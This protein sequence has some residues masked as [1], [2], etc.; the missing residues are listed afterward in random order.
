MP[1]LASLRRETRAALCLE[2]GKCATLCPLAGRGDFSARR[3]ASLHGDDP[4]GVPEAADQRC[5]TCAACE[6]RCPQQVHFS[7]WVRGLRERSDPAERW[8]CPHGS[9]LEASARL[10]ADAALR[11]DL[12]WI[13]DDLRVAEQGEIALFVGCLP[14]F[15]A[16]FGES[17]GVRTLDSARAAIRLLNQLGIEPVIAEEERCCGHDLLWTG[18]RQSFQKLAHG[19]VAA[20][21][22]RGV[23][24]VL[25][26]CAECCRTWRLDYA[27]AVPGTL[28]RVEHLSEFL[29]DRLGEGALEP[30]GDEA[31]VR[32]TYQD[33]CR[34][35]RHLDVV[36]APRRLLAASGEAELVEMERSGRDATCCG[37]PGFTHCDSTSLALQRQR[38]EAALL[39]GATRLLTACPK[40]LIHFRC[41]QQLQPRACGGVGAIEIQ[42]LTV[43]AAGRLRGDVNANERPGHGGPGAG[44]EP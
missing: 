41:A 39:T 6:R 10:M 3:I 15:D 34:L 37:T 19:N 22:E 13:D 7:D 33:P 25:T 8:P 36:D 1:E 18:D 12:S 43:F 2:C 11:R 16:Y 26:T 32:V 38:L 35:G 44:E 40:C 30:G 42:D 14:F 27:E 31:P 29:A 17:L 5:L 4:F 23:K 21:R 24:H 9:A 20:F 28:P